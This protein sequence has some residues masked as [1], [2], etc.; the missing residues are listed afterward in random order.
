MKKNS[1]VIRFNKMSGSEVRK[2][3]EGGK[4][5]QGGNRHKRN[6]EKRYQNNK[7]LMKRK[8]IVYFNTLPNYRKEDWK[9]LKKN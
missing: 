9:K 2:K 3:E 4:I 6:K 7:R 1:E 5:K 8:P